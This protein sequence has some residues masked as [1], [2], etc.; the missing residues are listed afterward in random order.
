MIACDDLIG[1]GW[2]RYDVPRK[3]GSNRVDRYFLSPAGPNQVKLRSV[4]SARQHHQANS[5]VLSASFKSGNDGGN[6]TTN[7]FDRLNDPCDDTSGSDDDV[8]NDDVRL[9]RGSIRECK[10]V[11]RTR[12]QVLEESDSDDN[13]VNS[14]G[15]GA[16]V[17]DVA[18]NVGKLATSFYSEGMSKT[19]DHDESD[20]DDESSVMSDSSDNTDI[21]YDYSPAL[22]PTEAA[23][24]STYERRC[25]EFY[26]SNNLM[27]LSSGHSIGV[28]ETLVTLFV[29][30]GSSDFD[31]LRRILKYLR[32]QMKSRSTESGVPLTLSQKVV[33]S[34]LMASYLG[35]KVSS[36]RTVRW[37]IFVLCALSKLFNRTL[38]V[39]SPPSIGDSS[40]RILSISPTRYSD[41]RFEGGSEFFPTGESELDSDEDAFGEQSAAQR[42]AVDPLMFRSA[43][44]FTSLKVTG[45]FPVRSVPDLFDSDLDEESSSIT[46]GANR[47]SST[48]NHVGIAGS[49][50]SSGYDGIGVPKSVV[51]VAADVGGKQGRG[52]FVTPQ[53]RRHHDA[54]IILPPGKVRVNP[55]LKV[56][57]KK[58]SNADSLLPSKPGSKSAS[59]HDNV[60]GS[61]WGSSPLVKESLQKKQ[62]NSRSRVVFELTSGITDLRTGEKVHIGILSNIGNALWYFKAESLNPSFKLWFK[63]QGFNAADCNPALCYSTWDD[64]FI[65]GTHHGENKLQRR[66]RSTNGS[67]PYPVSKPSCEFRSNPNGFP[68][69][70]LSKKFESTFRSMCDDGSVLA[71]YLFNNLE[72][73]ASGMVNNFLAGNYKKG[74][75]KG[76]PYKNEDELKDMFRVDIEDTFKYGFA[77]IVYNNHFDKHFCDFTIQQFLISLGYNSFDD[78]SEDERSSIYK[79]GTFPEWDAISEEPISG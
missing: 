59:V 35:G 26:Y 72:E 19:S 52:L 46:K 27:E 56:D 36:A 31:T 20:C 28:L 44:N 37:N 78:I 68:L 47:G 48:V 33:M 32:K 7:D 49:S 39:L 63:V 25:R 65:R 54:D 70:V 57:S 14:D 61:G 76:N 24:T 16:L 69:E 73:N 5:G 71:S 6:S 77:R 12:S 43:V 45:Y 58:I 60:S 62:I 30:E 8:K 17:Q 75:E 9:H 38:M 2:S 22:K 66:G 42:N 74:I 4:S 51:P 18:A 10:R 21:L 67:V 53:K 50:S 1:P 79:K 15:G 55:Y 3:D 40:V 29:E 11:S 23:F 34:D 64:K 41:Y 13:D